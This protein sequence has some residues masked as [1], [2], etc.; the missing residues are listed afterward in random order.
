MATYLAH[1]VPLKV[2]RF[3]RELCRAYMDDSVDL[4]FIEVLRGGGKSTWNVC[5]ILYM[6]TISL[7]S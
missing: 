4:M 1:L 3:Q 7:A 2:A 5:Y 6:I